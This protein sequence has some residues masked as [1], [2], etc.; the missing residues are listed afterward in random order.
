HHEAANAP[1]LASVEK[2]LGPEHV[3]LNK[4][5][6][7]KNGTVDV[8]F[9]GKVKDRV[10]SVCR[11][12]VIE[13]LA[14]ANVSFDEEVTLVVLQVG[15]ILEVAG[16]GELVERYHRALRPVGTEVMD[17]IRPDEAARACD[18]DVHVRGNLITT[19]A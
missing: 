5:F 1:S 13:Q 7:A 19:R 18:E 15:K 10:N 8:T 9:G 4:D 17:Q 11:D 2:H 3:G 14:V 16:V 12:D 6:G